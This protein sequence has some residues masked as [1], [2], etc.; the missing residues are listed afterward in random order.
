MAWNAYGGIGWCMPVERTLGSLRFAALYLLAGLGGSCLSVLCHETVSAGASG[1]LF[2]VI[3]AALVL[4]R[5]TVG[6][7]AAFAADQPSRKI[8]IGIGVWTAIGLT[9][10]SMDH[11]AHLGGF[12]VGFA[13][14][15]VMTATVHRGART[16]ATALGLAALVV[17]GARPGWRPSPSQG[18]SLYWFGAQYLAGK[19][20]PPDDRRAARFLDAACTAG[21]RGACVDLAFMYATGRHFAPDPQRAAALYRTACEAKEPAACSRLGD[22]ILRGSDADRVPRALALFRTACTLGDQDGCAGAGFIVH[23]GEGSAPDQARGMKMIEDACDAGSAWGCE[24]RD[25]VRR[26]PPRP[27]AVDRDG[28]GTRP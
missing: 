11:F 20:L 22:L 26:A 23:G 9:A 14:A 8:L 2:G 1:A 6:G 5:R 21:Q 7:W 12:L 4:R 28:A 13:V 10:V 19:E 15:D 17:G 25:Q 16:A 18:G 27:R 3:G 24:L